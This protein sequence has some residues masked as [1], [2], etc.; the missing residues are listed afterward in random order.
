MIKLLS[1]CS[2]ETTVVAELAG[3]QFTS[4]G[5]MIKETNWLDVM[6]GLDFWNSKSIPLFIEGEEFV[7]SELR[8]TVR[9]SLLYT[10]HGLKS[11]DDQRTLFVFMGLKS[12]LLDC[13][14]VEHCFPASTSSH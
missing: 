6:H 7:P 14:R 10:L 13:S 5:L 2:A 11:W 1:L 9:S 4:K 12:L 3:E 8:M